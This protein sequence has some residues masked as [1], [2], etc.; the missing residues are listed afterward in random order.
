MSG[1][2]WGRCGG[3]LIITFRFF[4]LSAGGSEYGH[5]NASERPSRAVFPHFSR[6][7]TS[8]EVKA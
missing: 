3:V 2:L 7:G 8:A 5:G 1:K 6:L 4:P